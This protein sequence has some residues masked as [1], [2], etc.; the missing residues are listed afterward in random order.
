[1][2][3]L[4]SSFGEDCE[5]YS[6]TNYTIISEKDP[7]FTISLIDESSFGRATASIGDV[8]NNGV[9]DL[10]VGQ[11]YADNR[12]GAVFL[13]T[14]DTDKTV[15]ATTKI[16]HQNLQ[17]ELNDQDRFGFSVENIGDIN[18]DGIDDLAVGA[19]Q[20]DDGTINGG[21]V[22]ILFMDTSGQIGSYS[23]ISGNSGSLQGLKDKAYLGMTENIALLGD[24]N[25]DGV[26]DI[27]VGSAQEGSG[28]GV[29]ILYLT[30]QGTVKKQHF[31]SASNFTSDIYPAVEFGVILDCLGDL[32]NDGMPELAIGQR[33]YSSTTYTYSK[34][35]IHIAFFDTDWNLKKYNTISKKNTPLLSGMGEDNI[36]GISIENAGDVNGDGIND[37]M[38]G[39]HE[40]VG[41]ALSKL[42]ILTLDSK[43]EPTSSIEIEPGSFPEMGAFN[44]FFPVE[45]Y[46]DLDDDGI[47]DFGFGNNDYD[48]SGTNHGAIALYN[49]CG[50][51]DNV[52][53]SGN[54]A[55]EDA[56]MSKAKVLLYQEDGEL[57]QKITID[58]ES[59]SFDKVPIGP[60]YIVATPQGNDTTVF[61]SAET[62]VFN[63]QNNYSPSDLYLERKQ[64]SISIEVGGEGNDFEA[65]VILTK[66][67]T[68][69][70]ETADTLYF[71]ED[72][73]I[74]FETD[75]GYDYTVAILPTNNFADLYEEKSIE[76]RYLNKDTTLSVVPEHITHS[77]KGAV[78][79]SKGDVIPSSI[80]IYKVAEEKDELVTEMQTSNPFSATVYGNGTFYIVAQPDTDFMNDY[81][82]ATTANIFVDSDTDNIV[83]ELQSTKHSLAGSLT[84]YDGKEP[85]GKLLLYRTEIS[86]NNLVASMD[87]PSNG[88][89]SF[90][91]IEKGSYILIAEP[92]QELSNIYS[93][94]QYP[95]LIVVDANIGGIELFFDKPVGVISSEIADAT[96]YPNPASSYISVR[97][98]TDIT[99]ITIHTQLG[100]IVYKA[101][102]RGNTPIFIGNLLPGQ[103]T[104]TIQTGTAT[105]K[106]PLIIRH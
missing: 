78:I 72:Y 17:Q 43:G 32:D 45:N 96:L 52:T 98:E 67:L 4:A 100:S 101:T 86:D 39:S 97:T 3:Q 90:P 34:G 2:L 26:N 14:L 88:A 85:A 1:M 29:Y 12:K 80:K 93:R 64:Y 51:V 73:P 7:N 19:S 16:E 55:F 48:G 59:Y 10:V 18:G 103:Y 77:I 83:I 38:A 105:K 63:A 41:D 46:G 40:L 70:D 95:E 31:I 22:F 23:K 27:A 65:Q 84:T 94:D 11:P 91:N 56:L 44:A 15:L 89:F 69:K 28:Q 71:P 81:L 50:V 74:M 68:S 99:A 54:V 20:H 92:S 60:Y 106:I 24:V 87:I 30:S 21:A 62:S 35:A 82:I 102:V 13:V 79:N 58:S 75:A 9:K 5:K 49:L 8:D 36:F 104:A 33:D 42:F 25:G 53:I 57:A 37:L 6:V 76:L 66:K 61:K 47:T